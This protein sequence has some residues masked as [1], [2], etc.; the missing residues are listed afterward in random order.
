MDV[1]SPLAREVAAANAGQA[2]GG[3]VVKGDGWKPAWDMLRRLT[4]QGLLAGPLHSER[5]ARAMLA[6]LW[7]WHDWLDESHQISQNLE[8]ATGSFWHAIMHRREG[9]FS[10]AKYWYARCRH[11][12]ALAQIPAMAR[13]T[14]GAGAT[15]TAPLHDLL[16]GEWD[17]DGFV[18]VVEAVHRKGDDPLHATAVKLQQIEWKALFAHCAQRAAGP[19]H[20]G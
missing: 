8:T 2:Y 11:H 13:A 3:L 5:H 4:P 6:G 14:L 18:D 20:S 9:D 19:P 16:K 17:P 10:N 15:T 7:L 1:L 12:P